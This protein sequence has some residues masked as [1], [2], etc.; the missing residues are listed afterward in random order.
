MRSGAEDA[1]RHGASSV[2]GDKGY[3]MRNFVA[4]RRKLCITPHVAQNI[5]H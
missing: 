2:A 5:A 1:Q 3:D 4:D